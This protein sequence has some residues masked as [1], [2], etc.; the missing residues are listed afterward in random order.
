MRKIKVLRIITRLNIG[1]PAIH[2]ILLT[3]GLDKNRFE[4]ILV[5][6]LH[7]VH[8]GDMSYLAEEKGIHPAYL[9]ELG[10][11]INVRN[12]IIAFY[13]L[14]RL[15]I[16]E[17]PDIIH[18]HTAKAGTLGRL[19]GL[20]Y[21]M[22]TGRRCKLV[23]TFHGHIFHG[24]FS[25]QHT[26]IFLWVERFL[27]SIT[28]RIITVSRQQYDE[29]STTL[30]V[31]RGKKLTV[32]PLGFDL[33]PYFNAEKARGALRKE[34]G[35]SLDSILIGMVG[36][37][38]PIKNHKFLLQT[39]SQIEEPLRKKMKFIIVGDGELRDELA[40]YAKRLRIDDHIVFTGWRKNLP[41]IYSDLDI[42]T[43]TSLNEGTPI[44]VIEAMA[45]CRPVIASNVGGV[46][47]LIEDGT[48][49]LL[50][51]RNNHNELCSALMRLA[52][53]E[54]MRSAMG[55]E[56]KRRVTD[57]YAAERLIKDI[58]HLYETLIQKREGA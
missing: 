1:G 37:L 40:D 28:D 6:G 25:K 5:T 21:K 46:G 50:F 54:G 52:Q 11:K 7:E 33:N 53:D 9:P 48:T 56:A 38:V 30:N 41:E 22:I 57:L 16:K 24:Y 19:A 47:D 49:G 31:T 4:S 55:R 29:I 23:H 34:F 12:D 35:L 2:T 27:A 42:V 13:K 20:L 58:E 26:R 44:S 8:E 17:K 14:L 3:G 45:S 32:V 18:T 36:R 10:R 15:M 51:Q 43:L 39:V